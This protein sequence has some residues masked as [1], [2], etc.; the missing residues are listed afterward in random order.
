MKRLRSTLVL[1]ALFLAIGGY[2]WFV[3]RE[4][5]PASEADANE[6]AF[7]VAAGRITDLTVNAANGDVTVLTPARR[8]RSTGRLPHPSKPR[9]TTT[10]RPPSQPPWP[11]S[12]SGG[13]SRTRPRIWR[14]SDW[15]SRP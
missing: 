4:R 8:T 14:R 7:D 2:A 11:R 3:E 12:R 15:P 6:Q 13:S 10:R 5:P 9:R 1:L